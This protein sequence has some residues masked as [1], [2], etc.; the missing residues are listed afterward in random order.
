MEAQIVEDDFESTIV[1]LKQ[2][3]PQGGPQ[4]GKL[5]GLYNSDLP[6]VL[7]NVGAGTSIGEVDLTCANV[8]TTP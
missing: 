3:V 8:W 4:S 2:G 1:Q 6:D 5:F 7:Q